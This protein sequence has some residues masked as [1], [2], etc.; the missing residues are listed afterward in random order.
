L[1]HVLRP[2]ACPRPLT[3]SLA[4][5]EDIA[6]E[7]FLA[8]WRQLGLLRQP[9]LFRSWICGIARNHCRR[10]LK[11]RRT[12]SPARRAPGALETELPSTEPSPFDRLVSRD[13]E[14][15][16]WCALNKLQVDCRLT[17]VPFYREEQSIE[18]L[19]Q[20][21]EVSNDAIKQRLSRGRRM[22]QEQM[23]ASESILSR[24]KPG[25]VLTSAIM[26]A[27][28]FA[29]AGE[30]TAAQPDLRLARPMTWKPILL[31]ATAAVT[32]SAIGGAVAYMITRPEGRYGRC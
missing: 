10:A 22:L 13:E 25:K 17:I 3:G 32:L 21:L 27:L 24:T 1:H 23:A 29:A 6:Q 15:S 11:A 16:L 26:L 4:Q 14:R 31:A 2:G 28:S 19:A 8:A 30:A 12:H 5:S 20:A 7:T 18:K 9:E